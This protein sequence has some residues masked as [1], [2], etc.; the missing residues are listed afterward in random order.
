MSEKYLKWQNKFCAV[1]DTLSNEKLFELILELSGPGPTGWDPARMDYKWKYQTAV[2]RFRYE[3]GWDQM[4]APRKGESRKVYIRR[5]IKYIRE[6]EGGSHGHA[7]HKAV[8]LWAKY[9]K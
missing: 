7:Y 1:I 3:M 2:N 8:G 5:A 9:K 6:K 4:P